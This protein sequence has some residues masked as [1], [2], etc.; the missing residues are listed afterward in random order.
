MWKYT[1]KKSIT[2]TYRKDSK[3][4]TIY[5]YRG[6]YKKSK[7]KTTVFKKNIMLEID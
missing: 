3:K 6:V 5:F 1:Q 2:N 4:K 7:P